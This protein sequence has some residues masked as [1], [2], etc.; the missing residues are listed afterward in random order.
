MMNQEG[1]QWHLD[2]WQ[3]PICIQHHGDIAHVLL[4]LLSPAAYD[5]LCKIHWSLLPA[6]CSNFCEMYH[7]DTTRSVHICEQFSGLHDLP[8]LPNDCDAD[9]KRG[10]YKNP[11]Y[12]LEDIQKRQR[13]EL[14]RAD[15]IQPCWRHER[16]QFTMQVCHILKELPGYMQPGQTVRDVVTRTQLDALLSIDQLT[17]TIRTRVNSVA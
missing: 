5:T 15:S 8:V 9:I 4:L 10:A 16:T 14:G 6:S 13:R 3:L 1:T 11:S 2:R 17:A 12:A 7:N